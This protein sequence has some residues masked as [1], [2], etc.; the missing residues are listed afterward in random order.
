LEATERALARLSPELRL[1]D[2]AVLS[3]LD[4]RGPVR[5]IDVADL[6]QTTATSVTRLIDRLESVDMVARVRLSSDRREIHVA[7]RDN[8][9]AI[10]EEI[11]AQQR[12]HVTG[13]LAGLESRNGAEV[14]DALRHV[15][16]GP[17]EEGLESA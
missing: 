1:S 10:V 7:I 8:G 3:L 5:L 17:V 14:I 12:S 6:L 13:S 9:R 11:R 15:A 16:N 2:L 4:E